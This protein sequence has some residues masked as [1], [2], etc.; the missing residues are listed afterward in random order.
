MW[1]VIVIVPDRC[2]SFYCA[3]LVFVYSSSIIAL[4][5]VLFFTR[6]RILKKVSHSLIAVGAVGDIVTLYLVHS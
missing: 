2:L 3:N 6:T 4:S 1:D 5:F